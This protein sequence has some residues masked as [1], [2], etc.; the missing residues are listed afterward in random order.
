M[1]RPSAIQPAKPSIDLRAQQ[2]PTD[3]TGNAFIDTGFVQVDGKL[4]RVMTGEQENRYVETLTQAITEVYIVFGNPISFDKYEIDVRTFIGTERE[5]QLAGID[6][7]NVTGR[8]SLGPAIVAIQAI[9]Y[10]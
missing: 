9:A 8:K 6:Y 5:F 7:V 10:V 4:F 1:L 3:V 2:I